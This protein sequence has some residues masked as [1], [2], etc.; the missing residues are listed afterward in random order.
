MKKKAKKTKA[1]PQDAELIL[2][3]YD[4]RRE[5]TL[6]KARD[7]M[8]I[9]F[10]PQNYDE[11]KAVAAAFG[12]EQNA[13]F[14]M[15]WTYWDMACAMALNGA[16]NEDLFFKCGGEPYFIYAKFKQFIEPLR[17]ELDNPEFMANI[18]QMATKSPEA[19]QRVKR[20]EQRIQTRL[21]PAAA[22]A[23]GAA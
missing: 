23:K 4:L 22:K 8:A 15:V 9:Q 7:F 1:T 19:R 2:K 5:A 3:L 16:I 20:I 10:W 14:R 12:S 6:R 18:E 17:K 21:A 13:W 11:F